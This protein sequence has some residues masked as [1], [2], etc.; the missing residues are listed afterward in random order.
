MKKIISLALCLTFTIFIATLSAKVIKIPEGNPVVSI[1]VP[2]SWGPESTEKGVAVESSDK[3]ATVFF[4]V[5][6]AKGT[7]ALLDENIA[8][9]KD[10]KVSIDQSS[11]SEKDFK[12]ASMSWSR[13]SWD[14]TSEEW[15]P[16]TI[17]FAFSDV[18]NGK[19]LVVTYWITKKGWEKH[20]GELS[21]IF[22]SV[23]KLKG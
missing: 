19:V 16:A 4:E 14:G 12:T 10:Q 23:K 17:G 22:D 6:S 9:L 5:T 15:G 7:D 13:I 18:G 2:D 20:D 8:W 11:K 3:E 1:D 21:K